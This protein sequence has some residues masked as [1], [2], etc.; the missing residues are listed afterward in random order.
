LAL[1]QNVE[2]HLKIIDNLMSRLTLYVHF[3]FNHPPLMG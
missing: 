1:Q 3:C 2:R